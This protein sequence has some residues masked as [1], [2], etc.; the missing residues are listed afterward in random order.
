MNYSIKELIGN[1]VQI[2]P[3]E[4]GHTKGLWEA[5]DHEDIWTHLPQHIKMLQE[6][7]QFVEDALQA[8]ETGAEYPFV[9]IEEKTGKIIGTTR[10]WRF[11]QHIKAWRL[12][13]HGFIHLYGAH[14]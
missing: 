2:V 14:P 6:M 5:G 11:R 8:K 7:S 13:G 4:R 3:M 9:V 12:A 10:F 1:H